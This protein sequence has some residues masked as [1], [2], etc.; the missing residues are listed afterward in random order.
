[1]HQNSREIVQA[2]VNFQNPE[3]LP[4]RLPSLKMDD[5]FS[6]S[7]NE[8]FDS[9][10]NGKIDEWS[11]VWE[12]TEMENMGQ[13]KKHP[14]EDLRQIEELVL[15]NYKL[16]SYYNGVSDKIYDAYKNQKYTTFGIFMI[17]FERMHAVCGF[18]NVLMGLL[19]EKEYCGKLA[20][21]I[22]NTQIEMVY[23]CQNRF[24]NELNAFTMTE[25]WGTQQAAFVSMDLWYDFFAPRYK[26]LFDIMHAG[27]QDVWVHSCGKVNEIIQGFID[28]GADVVNLQQPRALGIK[29]VGDRYRGKIS[30]ESLADIQKT[31][32]TED[33]K[34]IFADAEDLGKNWMMPEGG[35]IFSDYGEGK[36]I[37]ATEKAKISMYKAFSKVSKEIYG[38][39]LPELK[40]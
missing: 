11:C 30:F 32:P 12:Q 24:G 21:M 16:D 17:L 10:L 40:K 13:V 5:T 2:A 36:A 3:R 14:I 22:L 31:L 20:D 6:I 38:K 18:E 7:K 25:D 34:R 28:V 15:P 8:N 4:L 29:E 39:A 37:G 19:T 33:E 26:K 35:F 1:M 23:E 27:G 9:G